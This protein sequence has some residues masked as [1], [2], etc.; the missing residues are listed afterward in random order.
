MIWYILDNQTASAL[1]SQSFLS[2]Q[3]AVH[4][5]LFFGVG[6]IEGRESLC[7]PPKSLIPTGA[8]FDE[9]SFH[10]FAA[11]GGE[12]DHALVDAVEDGRAVTFD[13]GFTESCSAFLGLF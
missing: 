2:R 5:P 6:R 8:I 12:K 9:K 7:K 13:V 1:E 4:P 3:H 10:G 11:T